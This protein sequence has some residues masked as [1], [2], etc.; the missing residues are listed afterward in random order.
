MRILALISHQ[1]NAFQPPKFVLIQTC[2]AI[3][4]SPLHHSVVIQ[5]LFSLTLLTF[6]YC[7]R[8]IITHYLNLI[9]IK[10]PAALNTLPSLGCK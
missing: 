4:V 9:T 10:S 3:I 1:L 2:T 5:F 8:R 6:P 7:L